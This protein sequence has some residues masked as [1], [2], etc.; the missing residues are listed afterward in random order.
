M[1]VACCCCCCCYTNMYSVHT[2]HKYMY[3]CKIKRG[4]F[5]MAI[6]HKWRCIHI[7]FRGWINE[8]LVRLQFSL[9]ASNLGQAMTST[10]TYIIFLNTTHCFWMTYIAPITHSS[11]GISYGYGK[12]RCVCMSVYMGAFILLSMWV[13]QHS[14]PSTK[15]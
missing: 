9:M 6:I 1:E 15:T 2:P 11:N 13:W 4:R 8:I 3:T 14:M 12:K 10:P 5:I 7:Q